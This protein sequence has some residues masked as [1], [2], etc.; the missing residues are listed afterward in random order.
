MSVRGAAM[1]VVAPEVKAASKVAGKASGGAA[2]QRAAIDAI[3]AKRPTA[4]ADQQDQAPS[5]PSRGRRAWNATKATATDQTGAPGWFQSAT[6]PEPVKAAN[7]GSG[8]VLGLFLW[9]GVRAY[10]E[11]GPTGVKNLLRAKFFNKVGDA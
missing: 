6:N 11:G 2:S 1:T 5:G 3:K 8:F 9:V 7:A 10:L 4:P